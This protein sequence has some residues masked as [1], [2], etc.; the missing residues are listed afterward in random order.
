MEHVLFSD[1]NVNLGIGAASRSIAPAQLQA[2]EELYVAFFNRVPEADGLAFWIGRVA[3]GQPLAE[4]ADAFYAAAQLYPAQTHYNAGMTSGN[5][6]DVIY[7][8]VLGRTDGADAGGLAYWTHVLDSGAQSRGSLVSTILATAHSLAGDP[9]YGWVS[10]L[11]DNKAAVAQRFA[12]EMGL[13]YNTA[14][15]SIS[16]GMQIAAAVTATDTSAAIALIGVHDGFS[17]LA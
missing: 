14:E 5:F 7:R 1:M 3:A 8:N 16:H 13:G 11:L 17:T 4:I 12:V 10:D 15:A 6:V 9:N 2:L